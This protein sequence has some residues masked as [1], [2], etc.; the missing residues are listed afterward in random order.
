MR[1]AEPPSS[2]VLQNSRGDI[3]LVLLR[4]ASASAFL[5]HGSAIL[6][7]AFN[8]PGPQQFAASHGWSPAIGYLVGLAQVL[9]GTAVLAGILARVGATGL[10]VVMTGAIVLVHL[11][12]GFDVSSGGVEYA[13]TQLMIAVAIVLVGPGR[14]SLRR[15][16]PA[17]LQRL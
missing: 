17:E 13:L 14:Y 16:L 10:I 1:A 4:L 8:G 7:G 15:F 6:V 5:Y 3:A 2:G 9:G 12:H 11:P